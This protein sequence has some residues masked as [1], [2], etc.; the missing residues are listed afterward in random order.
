MAFEPDE[1]NFKVLLE[2][3]TR[4]ELTN[5]TPVCKAL[6]TKT[7]TISFRMDNTMTAGIPIYMHYMAPAPLVQVPTLGLAD[8]IS[9]YG[10]PV[11]VKMDIEG[12]ELAV[13]EG[14]AETLAG[15]S[16]EWAI[17]TNHLVNGAFT[18]ERL[19]LAFTRAGYQLRTGLA[20]GQW[21]LWARRGEFTQA[22]E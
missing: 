21:H 5:V 2:N 20:D 9:Q 10:L 12:A 8:A 13:I 4:H 18:H 16:I 14:A 22:A 15:T 1:E 6:D 19:A 3:I 11:Y 7:G 17:E